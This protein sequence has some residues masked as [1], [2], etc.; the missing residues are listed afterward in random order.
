MKDI[1]LCEYEVYAQRRSH[2]LMQPAAVTTPQYVWF[3]HL[4]T[5]VK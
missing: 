4:R 5:Y 2:N 1:Q 3:E